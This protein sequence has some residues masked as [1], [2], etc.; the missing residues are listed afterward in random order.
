[1]GRSGLPLSEFSLGSWL[2]FGKQIDPKA[3]ADNMKTAYDLGINFFDNAE[4]YARGESERVMGDVLAKMQWTRDSYIVS[5]KAFF[6]TH[7][8]DASPVYRGLHRKHL[9]EACHQTLQRLRL[10]YL[11][12]YYCHRPDKNT[13]IEEVVYTMHNLVQQGKILYWGT[14]E[15]SAQEIQAAIGIAQTH[16]LI[17][18]SVEQCQYNLMVREKMESEY[19]LLFRDYGIGTTIWSPLLSGVLTGKYNDGFPNENT[20]LG[21]EG[22]EWLRDRVYAQETIVKVRQLT[23]LAGEL[24]ITTSRLSLAWCLRNPNVSTVILGASRPAQITENVKA[25]GDV[26]LLNDAVMQRI[27]DIVQTSPRLPEF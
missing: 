24:G 6:G 19:L 5:G 4:V 2:T 1:M 3:A 20:R 14:S 8:P 18:P 23:K 16:H 9:V 12:L 22:L 17:G 27:E 13:P 15:W 11:D 26:A 7:G 10:D 25:A 21:M